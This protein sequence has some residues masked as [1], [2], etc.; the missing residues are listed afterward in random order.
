MPRATST[1]ER[2]HVLPELGM[3]A[4]M[5]RRS[6]C[7]C[8]RTQDIVAGSLGARE[9]CCGSITCVFTRMSSARA[10]GAS[11]AKMAEVLEQRKH[12]AAI[13]THAAQAVQREREAGASL[14]ETRARERD[15]IY[16]IMVATLQRSLSSGSLIT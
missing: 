14:E 9:S 15:A 2:S 5:T 6:A 13:A 12:E 8:S 10:L 4:N 16:I 1:S 11:A 3:L 7:V